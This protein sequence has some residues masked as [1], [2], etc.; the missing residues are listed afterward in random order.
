MNTKRIFFI[1]ILTTLWLVACGGNTVEPTTV[2]TSEPP[3]IA[4]AAFTASDT[5]YNGPDEI[6]GGWV[7]ITLSNEGQEPHHIQLIRLDTGK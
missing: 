5:G 7:K 3:E 4:E 2:P 1:L 6:A